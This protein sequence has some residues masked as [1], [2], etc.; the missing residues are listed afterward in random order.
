MFTDLTIVSTTASKP[1]N[2]NIGLR[3]SFTLLDTVT[4]ADYFEV[5]FPAGTVIT[6]TTS[7]S[8]FSI[9]TASVTYNSNTGVMSF[10]Q[11]ALSQVRFAGFL[12]NITFLTYRTPNSTKP[13]DPILFRVMKNGFAK[14]KGAAIPFVADPKL[15]TFAVTPNDTRI[16]MAS[17]YT[18]ALNLADGL[19]KTGYIVLTV[20]P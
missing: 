19:D 13:T 12:A 15:Y 2:S 8:T 9:A 14:M 7:L 3:I 10:T 16:N 20:P 5:Q 17:S 1:I 18:I 4:N 11:T 6:Y